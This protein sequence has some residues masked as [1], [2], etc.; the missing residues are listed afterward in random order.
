LLFEELAKQWESDDKIP[1]DALYSYI[2]SVRLVLTESWS[3]DPSAVPATR[4]GKEVRRRTQRDLFW[5]CRYFTWE[6]NPA[7]DGRSVEYNLFT[8]DPYRVVCDLFV[9]K[10]PTKEIS[11]QDTFRN[12][13]L[14]WPRA[15]GKSTLDICDTVQ[16][17][18]CFPSVRIFYITA[19]E[20]LAVGFLSETKGHFLVREGDPTL[21]NLFFPEFCVKEKDKGNEYEFRCPVY[22]AKHSGRKEPTVY[23]TAVGSTQSGWHCEIMKG[24]DFVSNKNSATVEQCIKVRRGWVRSRKMLIMNVGFDDKIGT[25]YNDE[26]AYGDIIAKNVG[27]IKTTTGVNWTLTENKTTGTKILIGKGLQIKSEAAEQLR[28]EGRPVTYKEAGEAGCD[29]LI[30]KIL[31]YSNMMYEWALD[32][33]I[34]E[35]QINQDPKPPSSTPFTR[36]LLLANTVDFTKMPQR[37]PISH[38]W[39]LAFSTKKKRDHTTGSSAVWNEKGQCFVKN[40]IRDRFNPTDMAKAIVNLALQD[41]PFIIGIEDAGGSKLIEPTIQAEAIKTGDPAV[42]A[43]CNRI[44]WVPAENQKDAKRARM[45]IMHPWFVADRL[46]LAKHLPFLAEAYNEIERC[47][48]HSLHDDIPD[49]IARQL[50]YAPQI[51]R[52]I[53]KSGMDKY[54]HVDIGWNAIYEDD[55]LDFTTGRGYLLQH[56]PETGEMEWIAQP[57]ANPISVPVQMPDYSPQSETPITGMDPILGAGLF[58]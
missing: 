23:A 42:V 16:W 47:Q 15:G 8:E 33:E 29:L 2:Q 57:I 17:V 37:G 1:D 19:A 51:Q 9:K 55:G 39:D 10:D 44:D 4:L 6:T 52:E 28:K 41:H 50:K 31:S 30:P 40:L 45:A 11:E 20:D 13:V 18:L 48:L 7:C 38:F 27:E 36:E 3:S 34:F 53:Q 14:L 32:E 49:N 22:E 54:T 5:V 24:D 56:N 21:M 43:V 35:G 58:G 26:D 46:K 12:R 25:R